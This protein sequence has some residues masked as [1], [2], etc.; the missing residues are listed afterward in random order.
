MGADFVRVN[1]A[2]GQRTAGACLGTAMRHCRRAVE[3]NLQHGPTAGVAVAVQ[4]ARAALDGA[5]WLCEHVAVED[6]R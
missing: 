6:R 2:D 3:I 4:E 1:R 5:A